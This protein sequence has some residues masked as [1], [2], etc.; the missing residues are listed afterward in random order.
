[1]QGVGGRQATKGADI[2]RSHVPSGVFRCER[3]QADG[4]TTLWLQV[5]T[6]VVDENSAALCRNGDVGT[7]SPGGA[8]SLK[9]QDAVLL[10]TQKRCPVGA[11]ITTQR[12]SRST[13]L[14][15]SFDRRVAAAVI[16]SV[17]MSTCTRLS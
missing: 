7:V 12:S 16:S 2:G 3:M 5:V 13:T 6:S 17:S 1:M 4:P 15:P 14:A 11:S 10:Q 8:R 9:N